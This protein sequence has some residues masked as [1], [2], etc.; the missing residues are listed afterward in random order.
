MFSSSQKPSTFAFGSSSFNQTTSSSQPVTTTNDTSSIIT[1]LNETKNINSEILN[2]IKKLANVLT[3]NN[4][5]NTTNTNTNNTNVNSSLGYGYNYDQTEHKDIHCNSCSK[6]NINGNRYK[7]LFCKDYDLCQECEAL[8]I[9]VYNHAT[10]TRE[11]SMIK[12]K[13]TMVF[14]TMLNS[15]SNAF[16]L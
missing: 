14:N 3:T 9:V 8:N 12:I 2:E 1:C 10:H 5:T 16:T 11:H 13:N 15:V 6:K 4:T 7:C